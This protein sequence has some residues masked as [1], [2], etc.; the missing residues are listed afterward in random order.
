[1]P[2]RV[3]ATATATVPAV[4]HGARAASGPSVPACHGSATG[5]RDPTV[6]RARGSVRRR[7]A[8]R[9]A[10]VSSVPNA[11]Q[12][13]AVPGAVDVRRY[14]ASAGGSGRVAVS[15][16]GSH[17]AERAPVER[18]IGRHHHYYPADSPPGSST[19]GCSDKADAAVPLAPAW[20]GLASG[21]ARDAGST[22]LHLV[23]R[24]GRL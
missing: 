15:R 1:M 17:G 2:A 18:H 6:G 4:A 21:G 16:T 9:Q 13:A 3:A 12:A 7:A 8:A 23:A 22:E 24:P 10:R 5:T 20:S 11:R 19:G 14:A